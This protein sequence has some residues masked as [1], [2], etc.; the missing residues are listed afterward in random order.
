[1][2]LSNEE[3]TKIAEEVATKVVAASGLNCSCKNIEP[4]FLQAIEKDLVMLPTGSPDQD[5]LFRKLRAIAKSCGYERE[6][7]GWVQFPEQE[8]VLEKI[9]PYTV[10]Q[11][12]DDGDLTLDSK[13]WGFILVTT[14]GE[15]F[16]KHI[17]QEILQPSIHERYE[18]KLAGTRLGHEEWALWDKERSDYI[19]DPAGLVIV[20][21]DSRKYAEDAKEKFEILG[22]FQVEDVG[23]QLAKVLFPK[24]RY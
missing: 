21:G 2:A 7:E 24:I 18:V 15:V 11:E 8:R 5:A 20:I 9:G 13:N 3:I 1:M 14:N 6:P 16:T 12:H 10:V 23:A 4:A 17:S 19:R 22:Y